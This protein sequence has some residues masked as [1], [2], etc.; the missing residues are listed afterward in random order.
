MT[1]ETGNGS[2]GL[3]LVWEMMSKWETLSL[4]YT[5]RI[6]RGIH[7]IPSEAYFFSGS[8]KEGGRWSAFIFINFLGRGVHVWLSRVVNLDADGPRSAG[9]NVE[10][11]VRGGI[12]QF[13][14]ETKSAGNKSSSVFLV[15]LFRWNDGI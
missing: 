13:L 6:T 12:C 1:S 5:S 3:F 9:G 8:F 10:E 2:V 11:R 7:G 4:V 14:S 15:C